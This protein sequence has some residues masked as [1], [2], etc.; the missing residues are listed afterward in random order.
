MATSYHQTVCA[1]IKPK[2]RSTP[3]GTILLFTEVPPT[4]N[5]PPHSEHIC[6][7]RALSS[8]D[9]EHN[10]RTIQLNYTNQSWQER[11]EATYVWHMSIRSKILATARVAEFTAK[12]SLTRNRQNVIFCNLNFSA[13][14]HCIFYEYLI[15]ARCPYSPRRAWR[16]VYSEI[17]DS[18][19]RTIVRWRPITL[20]MCTPL[21][22]LH[23]KWEQTACC[24][25]LLT[26]PLSVC[27]PEKPAISFVEN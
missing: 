4:S 13:D 9:P 2:I 21:P 11:R 5:E 23:V 7:L 14:L 17:E 20:F 22:D 10:K 26:T 8:P 24:T 19:N 3:F 18:R 6:I 15:P 27:V 16:I 1:R 25:H 12:Q